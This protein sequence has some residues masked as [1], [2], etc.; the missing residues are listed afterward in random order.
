LPSTYKKK[1]KVLKKLEMLDRVERFTCMK[2]D[3]EE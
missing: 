1:F 2:V 3:M